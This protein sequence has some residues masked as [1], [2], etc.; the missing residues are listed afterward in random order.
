MR[1]RSDSFERIGEASMLPA[2]TTCRFPPRRSENQQ[3]PSKQPRFEYIPTIRL[4]ECEGEVISASSKPPNCL[5]CTELRQTTRP[6][7]AEAHEI[8]TSITAVIDG[9]SSSSTI[10]AASADSLSAGV[11]SKR[12]YLEL[13]LPTNLGSLYQRAVDTNRDKF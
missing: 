11:T 8:S 13:R 2:T 5:R 12:E 9:D 7:R 10:A 1:N 4:V 6:S 3:Q